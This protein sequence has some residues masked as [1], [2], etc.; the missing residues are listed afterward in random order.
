[1]NRRIVSLIL[2]P[3]VLLTQSVTFGHSHAGKQPAGHGLRAHIHV[4]T[5][6]AD[7]QHG[8]VHSHG[9]HCHKHENH[10]HQDRDRQ[11]SDQME[12]P[13]DHDSSALYLNS[14]DLTTGSRSNIKMKIVV[15][16]LW[17]VSGTGHSAYT[18][19]S[20]GPEWLV[21]DC[22]PPD[23]ASPLFIRHHAILI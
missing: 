14:T 21:H 23:P 6:A 16:I 10:S 20:A 19:P 17:N 12:S 8:H 22:A 1:M 5:P 3:F 7:E 13:F 18:L 2:M 4:N 11:T 9:T 15:L